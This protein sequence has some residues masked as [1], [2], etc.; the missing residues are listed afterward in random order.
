VA[1][2]REDP[3]TDVETFLKVS[4]DPNGAVMSASEYD[5][6]DVDQKKDSAGN[7]ITMINGVQV[8]LP[9]LANY[10]ET[11]SP[12]VNMTPVNFP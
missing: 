8:K 5:L 7:T 11:P 2:L 9:F 6:A 3:Q 1:T 10:D 4:F 12:L